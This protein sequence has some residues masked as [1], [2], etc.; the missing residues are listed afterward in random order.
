MQCCLQGI[1]V[2]DPKFNIVSPG[3]D[4]GLY[5]PYDKKDKRLTDLHKDI[6]NLLFGQD[7]SPDFAKG[8]LEDKKKP[9]IFSMARLD[10]PVFQPHY[11][12]LRSMWLFAVMAPC[13]L[14]LH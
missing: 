11:Q 7:E 9:I 1:N 13:W 6:E 10:R 14:I 4:Q 2:F 5:F 12:K 8:A 3:A